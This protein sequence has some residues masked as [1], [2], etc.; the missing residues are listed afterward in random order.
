MA[1]EST[2]TRVQTL[3]YEL[4]QLRAQQQLLEQQLTMLSQAR[5]EYIETRETIQTLKNKEEGKDIPILLPLGA[6]T[7]AKAKLTSKTLIMEVGAGVAL[8]KSLDS[9][10]SELAT[11]LSRAE[12]AIQSLEAQ[13]PKVIAAIQERDQM[14]RELL[15]SQSVDPYSSKQ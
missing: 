11:R 14:L 6:S 3:A 10:L 5:N 7:F 12:T 1:K 8:N 15:S 13:F 4:E 2:Q 9:V